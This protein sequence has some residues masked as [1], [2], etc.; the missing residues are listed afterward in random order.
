VAWA[1][2]DVPQTLGHAVQAETLDPDVVYIHVLRGHLLW[3]QEK[4]AEAATAY[5]TA[6][7]K[8]HGLPWQYAMAY[9]RLGRIYAAQGN[10][11]RALEQYDKAL[12]QHTNG[13][14]DVAIAYSNKGHL[15]ATMGRFQEAAMHYRQA[16]QLNP[17]D[18]LSAAL[19]QEVERR[20]RATQDRE[21]RERIDQLVA[22]LL[23][24]QKDGKPSAEQGD[25]WTSP[26][27]TLALLH[28]QT[29][30]TPSPRAGE[31]DGLVLKL[32]DALQATGRIIVVERDLLD[33]VL[34]ELK[35]GSSALVDLPVAVRLG[36]ILAARLLAMGTLTRHGMEAQ[37]SLRVVETETTRLRAALT[38]VLGS[39]D[40]ESIAVR[41]ATALVHKLRAAYPLQG[42]ILQAAPP[43]LLL[44]IG[45]EQG[46]TI[47]MTL[48]VLNE[49][50]LRLDG[51]VVSVRQLPVGLIEVTN[52]EPRLAQARVLEQTTIFEPGWKV[53]EK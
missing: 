26:P 52:V 3:Q 16:Q 13:H 51:K 48:Q 49:E 31:E 36:H 15:L 53:K 46:V 27:L 35:L 17:A 7:E 9:N 47:G 44:N 20:E 14:P 4:M 28:V 1:R 10:V 30:G 50:P 6:T 12:D 24:A 5:R 38:D 23:Q 45:A 32:V 39:P 18:R 21:K 11:Q 29:Q 41:L 8:A 40:I 43:D 33:K 22:S 2:G 34:T 37:L 42:R 19:L 25:G